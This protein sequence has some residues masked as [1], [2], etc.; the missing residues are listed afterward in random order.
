MRQWRNGGNKALKKEIETP[1]TI[2]LQSSF[3]FLPFLP[4]YPI[5]SSLFLSSPYSALLQ[6]LVFS[7]HLH[8]LLF[9]GVFSCL[10]VL[11]DVFVLLGVF[12]WDIVAVSGAIF[13]SSGFFRIP[14]VYVHLSFHIWGFFRFW[15]KERDIPAPP[16]LSMTL[17]F[18]SYF[19]F[20]LRVGF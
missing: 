10:C 4:S 12:G 14:S 20:C 19:I 15:S 11:L 7:A 16:L 5:F 2:N 6:V 17:V 9:S 1:L 13:S 3:C 8:R 18:S